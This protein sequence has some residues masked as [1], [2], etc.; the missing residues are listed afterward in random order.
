MVSRRPTIHF[1]IRG[2]LR[3]GTSTVHQMFRSRLASFNGRHKT[4]STASLA[5][6]H[7]N[8]IQHPHRAK[9]CL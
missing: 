7:R 1:T 9:S 8:L 5:T 4:T 3:V 6:H 2:T